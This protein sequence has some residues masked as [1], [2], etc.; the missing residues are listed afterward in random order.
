MGKKVTITLT[1]QTS[2][3]YGMS[4]PTQS[5]IDSQCSIADDNSGSSS[6]GTLEDFLSNVYND[7]DVKWIGA[8]N[9]NG[10]TVAIDNIVSKSGSIFD[11]T[12]LNGS[13]GRSGN[14]TG[15]VKKNTPNLQIDTYTINFSVFDS[16]N[17]S[18]SFSIDPKLQSNP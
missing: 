5:Q 18:K 17:A 1:V 8:S 13:G 10:F 11:S 7:Y 15:K 6:N 16:G 4:S 3:L 14:V 12:T 9:D 2:G